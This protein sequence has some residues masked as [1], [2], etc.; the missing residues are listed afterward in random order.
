MQHLSIFKLLVL[1]VSAAEA[2]PLTVTT[3]SVGTPDGRT[4]EVD[5]R[6]LGKAEQ[7][8]HP[9]LGMG[10]G[11]AI[12][13]EARAVQ[14]PDDATRDRTSQPFRLIRGPGPTTAKGPYPVGV[15]T[16]PSCRPFK[17]IRGPGQTTAKGPYTLG[18]STTAEHMPKEKPNVAASTI[19]TDDV[20][21]AASSGT[22]FD[23]IGVNN[24]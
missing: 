7:L 10:P 6:P 1:G 3:G 5:A 12:S 21:K 15:Q 2:R 19:P 14:L 17:V 13:A 20:N 16:D 8:T 4:A 11:P 22:I 18:V 9:L 24:Q 23:K